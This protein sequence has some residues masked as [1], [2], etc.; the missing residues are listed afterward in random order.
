MDEKLNSL[1]IKIL[2]DIKSSINTPTYKTWFENI[3]PSS[4]KNNILFLSVSSYFAKEWLETRYSKILNESIAKFLGKGYG[5]KILVDPEIKNKNNDDAFFDKDSLVT[6]SPKQTKA[7]N[8]SSSFNNKYSFDTFVVGNSNR[9]AF[10]AAKAVSEK[11]GKAYNPLFIYGGVGLGKTHLLHSIGQYAKQLFPE[12]NVRYIPA[13]KFLN[14]F[15]SALRY[16]NVFAFKEKYRNSDM[17]LIDDIQFLEEKEAS[18]EEFFHTF[19]TL[20]NKDRQIILTSDRSPRNLAAL[21][22]RPRSR[23]EW[24]LVTDIT[25]PDL[26][27]RIAILKV[28]CKRERVSFP[29]TDDILVLIASKVVSNIR[30][31]EG[32]LTRIVAFSSLTDAAIDL[33]LAKKVLKDYIPESGEQ[34]ISVSK[35]LKE[36][37]KYYSVSIN[38]IVSSKRSQL[39]AQA[40]QVGM[41]LSRE[42]TSNSLP[43]IGKD[44]GNRDHT[45][46]IYSINKVN[47]LIKSDRTIYNQIQEITNRIKT[48]T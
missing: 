8:F 3:Q 45:T 28:F 21:E 33:D 26:E 12:L 20:H 46:V 37:S 22:E 30:E 34:E 1:W 17:L 13:E 43:K 38:D 41:Y 6:P 35:I 4:L 29:V 19:N 32:A 5:L 24:G 11:P 15:I 23:L 31:L 39:I 7:Q 14:D 18:Q 16:K 27:T 47:D 44:F 42:L 10:N 25:Q 48:V 40:R 9:F 2:T 36:V